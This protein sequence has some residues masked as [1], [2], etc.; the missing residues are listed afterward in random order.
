MLKNIKLKL[1]TGYGLELNY[2]G[3]M[4]IG[5]I[6]EKGDNK[7]FCNIGNRDTRRYKMKT[8]TLD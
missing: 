6:T 2:I 7:Y 1:T 8:M 4:K 3:Q 5:S